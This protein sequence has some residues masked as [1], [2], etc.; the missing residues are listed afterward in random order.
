M[1]IKNLSHGFDS[2][3]PRFASV[4]LLTSVELIA[5]EGEEVAVFSFLGRKRKLA[6]SV[7]MRVYASILVFKLDVRTKYFLIIIQQ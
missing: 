2:M 7:C 6:R 5:G 4:F 1:K 3:S